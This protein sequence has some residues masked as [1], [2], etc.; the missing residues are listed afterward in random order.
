MAIRLH[1]EG[2]HSAVKHA[3]CLLQSDQGRN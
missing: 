3:Q 2:K 1:G